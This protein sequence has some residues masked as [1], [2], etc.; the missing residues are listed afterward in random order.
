M[1]FW[2]VFIERNLKGPGDEVRR[3]QNGIERDY[4][5]VYDDF[6]GPHCDQRVLHAPGVCDV[7]DSFPIYQKAREV[8][9]IAYTR[10]EEDDPPYPGL[11]DPA[12]VSR[13][14]KE[15]NAWGNNQPHTGEKGLPP[16][17]D[18]LVEM[19]NPE[20]IEEMITDLRSWK[21]ELEERDGQE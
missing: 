20:R 21:K 14:V 13:S 12:E 19:S 11:P 18:L 2:K 9:G 1:N 3:F 8:W 17:T 15:I 10:S 6:C 16:L 5:G 4:L 7:C